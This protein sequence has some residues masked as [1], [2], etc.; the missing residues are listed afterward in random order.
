MKNFRKTYLLAALAAVTA[1]MVGAAV[2]QAAKTDKGAVKNG[3]SW[4]R[5]TGLSQFPT[6]GTG[7]KA[8]TLSALAAAKKIG[9]SVSK[10]T[11]DRF[12]ESVAEEAT[13]YAGSAGATSKLIL[14]ATATGRNPRCFGPD[15]EKSD[16][17][18]ILNSD[19]NSSSGQYGKT[20]F[21]HALAM[22]GRRAAHEKIPSK[23]VNFAKSRRGQYGWNFAMSKSSGDDVESSALMIEA[24]RAA[25]MSKNNGALKSAY[26]WI[27][28]QRNL[29]GG[30]NPETPNGETQA[31]AT[32]Y[33]IR[34][35]DTL[36]ASTKAAKRALRALQKNGG[37]F[38]SSPSAGGSYPT[39]STTNAV[40]AL[41]GQHYPVVARSKAGKSCV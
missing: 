27:T 16:L 28:Y 6:G 15:G 10:K 19:Y 36:G 37:S 14:A 39:I 7:F 41:S 30:Y 13:D 2:A 29:D 21:D 34:A 25:G 17:I 40:L 18:A 5:S 32:A 38:R 31:D 26:K 35:F 12:I 22:L 11:T 9:V 4:I 1:L 3:V 33:A 24:L 8:D 20:S 23:A